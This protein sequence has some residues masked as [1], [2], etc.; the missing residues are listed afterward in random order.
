MLWRRG[1]SVLTA[2]KLM[3][4][5]DERFRLVDGFNLEVSGVMPQDAG[6]YI[7]EI[8]DGDNRH[9][10]HTVEILGQLLIYIHYFRINNGY[11]TTN[12]LSNNR[13]CFHCLN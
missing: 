4:T 3:V 7:C 6:D 2:D 1:S 5:R 8:G 10:I 13:L 11:F 12:F 9:Q